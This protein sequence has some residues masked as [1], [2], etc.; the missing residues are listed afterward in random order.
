[1][2]V[3]SENVSGPPPFTVYFDVE[4]D[5][6]P[7][8]VSVDYSDGNTDSLIAHPS[9]I[10][11]IAHTYEEY[12]VYTAFFTHPSEGVETLEI[13][14]EDEPPPED[15]ADGEIPTYHLEISKNLGGGAVS[16][17]IHPFPNLEP[18]EAAATAA[19]SVYLANGATAV[20]LGKTV[21]TQTRTPLN[22]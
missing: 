2:R 4:V 3:T 19:A 12:G 13:S 1:M 11:G 9:E 21:E 10:N 6:G 20:I 7:V 16:T 17:S 5:T 14:V 8:T 18:V 22:P 15:P